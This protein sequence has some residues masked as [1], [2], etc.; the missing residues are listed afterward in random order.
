MTKNTSDLNKMV[1]SH[2]TKWSLVFFMILLVMMSN[3]FADNRTKAKRIHD[4]IAGVAPSATVLNKMEDLIDGT[5]AVA[6]SDYPNAVD[7]AAIGITAGEI[8]AAY[9]A[10]EN[11]HF[12]NATLVNLITPWTNEA[13][14]AFPEDMDDEGILNDYTATVI[15]VIRDD[16]DFRR[17]LFDDILYVGAGVSPSY[18]YSSNAHYKVLEETGDNLGDDAVLVESTLSAN[19]SSSNSNSSLSFSD[20]AG[21]ITSRAAAKA[22]F[23]DGTNRAMFRFTV[24]NHL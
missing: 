8:A 11:K 12:F 9:V 15:G 1:Y 3:T 2:N 4:R 24:L 17:I 7:N 20:T 19:T 22:F 10:M 6:D 14:A 18:S 21:V 5:T 23:V 13:R 16:Y